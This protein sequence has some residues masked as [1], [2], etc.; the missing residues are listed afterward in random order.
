MNASAASTKRG[1][2]WPG[3]G[4]NGRPDNQP[5]AFMALPNWPAPLDPNAFH[6]LAG[7]VVRL[8]EPA[9]ESDPASLLLQFL[10]AVGN[11]IG[12]K[13][14][15]IVESTWHTTNLYLVLVGTTSKGRKGTSWGRVRQLLKEVAPEWTEERIQSGLVSGEGLIE[16]VADND[17]DGDNDKRL[18]VMQDEFASVLKIMNR[19]GNI[20]S[21]IIRSAWDS[22][23]LSS[24][25]RGKN[26]LH[27]TGAHVSLLG[28]ITRDELRRYLTE[29]ESGNGFGNRYLWAMAKRSKSLPEG[30]TVDLFGWQ[31]LV[32]RLGECVDRSGTIEELKRDDEASRIWRVVYE[33]LSEGSFGMF[34]AMTSRAEAQVVRLSMIYA[35]LD[36]SSTIRCEHLKA[37]LAVWKYCEDSAR[38]IFGRALG[39]PVADTILNRLQENGNEGLTRTQISQLFCRNKTA[40]Q[41]DSAVRSLQE[42]GRIVMERDEDTGGRPVERWR[43]L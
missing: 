26:A 21:A 33:R 40:N 17:K 9:S 19:E 13:A 2:D 18:L 36:G 35:V 42:Y 31:D 28:H 43:A 3:A 23:C 1:K 41:I 7:D 11:L 38:F 25:A 29:T 5:A 22:G 14:H 20:L 34:G 4:A 32:G 10:V 37:A 27:A 16:A 39:D 30:G 8:I 24:L 6:G 15:F 12:R